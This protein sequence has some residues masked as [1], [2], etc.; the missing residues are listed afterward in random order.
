R[1]AV[2]GMPIDTRPRTELRSWATGWVPLV[3]MRPRTAAA[4]STELRAPKL[5]GMLHFTGAT[6]ALP[7]TT[8]LGTLFGGLDIR[9]PDPRTRSGIPSMHLVIRRCSPC[10]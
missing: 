7:P 8:A 3:A 1:L 6:D 4:S 10:Y 5:T 2:T 9:A